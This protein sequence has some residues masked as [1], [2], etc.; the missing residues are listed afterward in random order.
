MVSIVFLSLL[1]ASV[2][3]SKRVSK[4]EEA[5]WELVVGEQPEV[6]L[7]LLISYCDLLFLPLLIVRLVCFLLLFKV[8]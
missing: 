3:L 5:A 1:L 8:R 7:T 4:Y 2:S 6:K